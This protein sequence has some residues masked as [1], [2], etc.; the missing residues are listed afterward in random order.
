L[1]ADPDLV[2]TKVTELVVMGGLVNDNFNLVRHN[3][4]E[5]TEYVIRNWPTPLVISQH[6]SE[7]RTGARLAAAAAENPVREAYYRWFGR[8]Y[9]GRSSW[10]QIAVLYAVRGLGEYFHENTS[11]KG[12]LRSGYEWQMTPGSRSYLTARL[13]DNEYA[14]TIEELMIK[15]PSAKAGT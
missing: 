12:R 9:Q 8:R 5:K 2:A 3:L 7:T 6:G 15:P 1:R 10:D 11:G 4:V 14:D 13:S